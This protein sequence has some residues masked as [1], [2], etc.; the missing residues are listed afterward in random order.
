MTFS[1]GTQAPR[2]KFGPFGGGGQATKQG[3]TGFPP[4]RFLLPTMILMA[5]INQVVILY[6]AGERR[7][8]VGPLFRD[9]PKSRIS[10]LPLHDTPGLEGIISAWTL[11]NTSIPCGGPCMTCLHEC[12]SGGKGCASKDIMLIV[13]GRGRRGLSGLGA[14]E[15]FYK[16]G[17]R[18]KY[19]IWRIPEVMTWIFMS[20]SHSL[21]CF[22]CS[23]GTKRHLVVSSSTIAPRPIIPMTALPIELSFL[24]KKLHEGNLTNLT[25]KVIWMPAASLWIGQLY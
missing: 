12:N 4:H 2:L 9:R 19:P 18:F 14:G 3:R 6:G 21:I 5:D 23:W 20:E 1:Q 8:P 16:K 24:W 25:E 15:D 10:G 17:S 11:L 13:D 7:P 22:S